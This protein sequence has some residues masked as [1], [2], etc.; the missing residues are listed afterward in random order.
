MP[1]MMTDETR[2]GPVGIS[3]HRTARRSGGCSCH[4]TNGSQLCC[5]VATLKG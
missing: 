2:D 4:G 5:S 1:E 3:A